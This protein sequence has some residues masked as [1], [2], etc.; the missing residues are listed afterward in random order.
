MNNEKKH[1]KY[2]L[3]IRGEMTQD[4]PLTI[5]I[6]LQDQLH[7]A[8]IKMALFFIV[9]VLVYTRTKSA[10]ILEFSIFANPAVTIL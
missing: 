9:T 3:S 7:W 6:L 10:K 8:E 4:C 1:T 2:F 5:I